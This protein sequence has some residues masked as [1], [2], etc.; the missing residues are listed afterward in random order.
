MALIA[1]WEF[2]RMMQAGG[3]QTIPFITLGLIALLLLDGYR[4]GLRLL[5][6]VLSAALLLSLSWQL[7][8]TGTAAPTA[9]WALTLAG[10]L[11]IGWGMAHPNCPA[12]TCRRPGLGMA[13]L[14]LN[15]GSRHFCLFCGT[16]R[17]P[18]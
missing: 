1:G 4:P 15:L 8:R 18:S 17:G 14:A 6:G 13:G 10:G 11:Y 2:G 12:P 9:D 16:R 5:N 3:Y 7:F